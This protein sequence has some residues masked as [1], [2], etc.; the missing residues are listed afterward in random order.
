MQMISSLSTF[1]TLLNNQLNPGKLPI[2]E[3]EDVQ[4]A[5]PSGEPEGLGD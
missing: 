1:L 4:E 2:E 3:A 5:V